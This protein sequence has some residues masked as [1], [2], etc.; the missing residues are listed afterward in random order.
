MLIRAG[1][2]EASVD[3]ARLAG[4]VSGGRH[5]RD[6]ERRRHDGAHA[7]SRAVRAAP[8]PQD[9]HHRGSDRLS[10]EARPPREAGRADDGRKRVRRQLRSAR[11]HH[12]GR[13]GRASGARQGRPLGAGPGAGARA[14]GQRARQ[15]CSASA[16]RRARVAGRQGHARDRA[17]RARRDRADPRSRPEE[18]VGLGHRG[19]RTRPSRLRA[20]ARPAAGGD[21]CRL[22][23]PARPRRRTT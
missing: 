8:R 13:A 10:P 4:L 18:R 7:G 15:I 9:R 2:T 19:C 14:C 1:H 3:L 16:S 17:R 21:R 12:D 11:L 6:H 20:R 23:D 22:A 5:L